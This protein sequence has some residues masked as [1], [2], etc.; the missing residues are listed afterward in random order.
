MSVEDPEAYL[1]SIAGMSD[2]KVRA[3]LM[4]KIG[5]NNQYG[6]EIPA[7]WLK[8]LETVCEAARFQKFMRRLERRKKGRK[9]KR[10]EVRG[11]IVPLTRVTVTRTVRYKY[12][13]ADDARLEAFYQT[14]EWHM[15]RYETLRRHGGRCQCCG[16]SPEDG[17][18]VLN[19]DHIK[20]VR[21]FWELRL[22]IDNLQVLCG[23]CNRGK[24]AR[25]TDDWRPE[26]VGNS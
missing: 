20:P 1:R 11:E 13:P 21:V 19:V 3:K 2:R 24:G 9:G 12:D 5:S 14:N 17:R 10:R 7:I 15:V 23:G 8:V 16:A 25:H 6:R 22:D 4:G 18:T 26:E